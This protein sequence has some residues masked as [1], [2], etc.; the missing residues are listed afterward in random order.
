[1][2]ADYLAYTETRPRSHDHVFFYQSN[3]ASLLYLRARMPRRGKCT[4]CVFVQECTGC[5][6]FNDPSLSFAGSPGGC[7]TW[8]SGGFW[9]CCTERSFNVLYGYWRRW[10]TL[11][12]TPFGHT[13]HE[14]MKSRKIQVKLKASLCS[15]THRLSGGRNSSSLMWRNR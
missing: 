7:V 14:I 6:I 12:H 8:L 11:I 9:D 2:T 1:M 13:S 10:S 15:K 3:Y 4:G 5:V